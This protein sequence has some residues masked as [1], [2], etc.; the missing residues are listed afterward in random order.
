MQDIYL[1]RSTNK[2]NEI[3]DQFFDDTLALK[4]VLELMN[5]H[6]VRSYIEKRQILDGK[7]IPFYSKEK[8]RENTFAVLP[9]TV[10]SVATRT[11]AISNNA[12]KWPKIW[13]GREL[14]GR[15]PQAMGS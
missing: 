1:V 5:D 12:T 3:L 11:G 9:Q 14:V 6:H 8:Q 4:K 15:D 7:I 13:D 10:E 2:H